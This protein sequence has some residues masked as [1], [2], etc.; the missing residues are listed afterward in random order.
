MHIQAVSPPLS[1]L[2]LSLTHTHTTHPHTHTRTHHPPPPLSLS[3]SL[4]HTHIYTPP[5]KKPP[6]HIYAISL[7]AHSQGFASTFMAAGLT[8]KHIREEANF[9]N[10][11]WTTTAH[12]LA[13]I[14]FNDHTIPALET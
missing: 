6:S 7:I 10:H 13:Q 3:F 1:S 4:S 9:T 8:L 12:V 2:S 5:R 11:D 14:K